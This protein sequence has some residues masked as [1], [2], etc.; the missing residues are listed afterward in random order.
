MVRFA[1]AVMIAA[2]A[3]SP[4]LAADGAQLFAQQCKICHQGPSTPLAPSLA[5]VAGKDKASRT[6]F[7]YSAALKAK[8][9]PWTDADLDKWLTSPG[10][11]VPGTK[12]VVAVPDPANRAAL[13]AYLK[14]L[15]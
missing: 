15:K 1:S 12:M 8:A 11:F 3:A 13:I 5:G 6:D 2:L 10:A 14:T 9:G 4:A 7:T